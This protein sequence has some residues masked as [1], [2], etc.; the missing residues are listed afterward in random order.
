MCSLL[1]LAVGVFLAVGAH[2]WDHPA[3]ANAA[4]KAFL[5]S[6]LGLSMRALPRACSLVVLALSAFTG[7]L[8]ASVSAN[9][10]RLGR[11]LAAAVVALSVLALPPLWRGQL[12]DANLDRAEEI[13]GHRT[14]AAA[15]LD[16]RDDG[17]RVLEVPGTDFASYRW[18]NTVDPVLPGLMDR[19]TRLVVSS[20]P[21]GSAASADLLSVLFDH[22]LQEQT[23][24]PEA[25]APMAR[26][27]GAGDI[28]VRS[29]LSYE[30]FNT[31]RPRTLGS[32]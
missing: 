28:S 3:P 19:P 12:V 23:F 26:F 10:P 30:R 27:L 7:A 8:I 20:S 31:P 5:E 15:A 14:E 1:L 21:Y 29:D 16:A 24:D 11:P 25:L 13:P 2:P 22:R 17:S 32:S 4:V 18:G 6:D 9:R